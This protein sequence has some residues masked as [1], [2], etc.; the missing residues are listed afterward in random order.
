M[1]ID[2]DYDLIL[3]DNSY[4][5]NNIEFLYSITINPETIT[6]SNNAV[7]SG[8]VYNP[9]FII[10]PTFVFSGENIMA[11][12][13]YDPNLLIELSNYSAG[14]NNNSIIETLIYGEPDS[15]NSAWYDFRDITIDQFLYAGTG[16]QINSPDF[17]FND[18]LANNNPQEFQWLFPQDSLLDISK[19]TVLSQNGI[20][21]VTV[22]NLTP[23]FGVTSILGIIKNI[24]GDTNNYKIEYRFSYDNKNF[25][26]WFTDQNL[27]INA[28]RLSPSKDN[29]LWPEFRI[30]YTGFKKLY[31]SSIIL[32]VISELM[33]NP[34]ECVCKEAAF[35]LP[36][37]P[38]N[39]FNPYDPKIVNKFLDF[40]KKMSYT[41][42][43]FFGHECDYIRIIP[44]RD[45]SDFVLLED[46]LYKE[47]T[48]VP[49]IGF[50]IMVNNNEFPDPI[51]NFTPFGVEFQKPFE[52]HIDINYFQQKFG[53]GTAPQKGDI[54]RLPIENRVYEIKSSTPQKDFMR[55]TLYWRVELGKWQPRSNVVLSDETNK[56]LKDYTTSVSELFGKIQTDEIK[57]K[58][59]PGQLTPTDRYHDEN[60]QIVNYDSW[61]E[62]IDYTIDSTSIFNYYYDNA[63]PFLIGNNTPTRLIEYVDNFDFNL[64]STVSYN[65]WFK[66]VQDNKFKS[67]MPNSNSIV[68]NP[69]STYTI[70]FVQPIDNLNLYTT[71]GWVVL[72]D[73]TIPNFELYAK[74]IRLDKF[75]MVVTAMPEVVAIASAAKSNWTATGIYS[76]TPTYTR[77]FFSN[78]KAGKGILFDSF[79]LNLYRVQ[80]N[81]SYFL[82]NLPNAIKYDEW[83]AV[84][85]NVS[86]EFKEISLSF[87]GSNTNRKTTKLLK[88][89]KKQI[90]LL[91]KPEWLLTDTDNMSMFA[92]NMH[93]TNIRFMKYIINDDQ[94]A[95]FNTQ[96]IINDASGAIII[97][98]AMPVSASGYRGQTRVKT[99][100]NGQR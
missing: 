31:V 70:S 51:F 50:K 78:W 42:T 93:L 67:K 54:I 74:I 16:V 75:S 20:T 58:A 85:L 57:D 15:I 36:Q 47:D 69:D 53:E 62:K 19:M 7:V 48:K 72:N 80:L 24:Y 4:N 13:F 92:G 82:F 66:P 30:Q 59:N 18:E 38:V 100:W 97:D 60:R 81:N 71:G 23:Y 43:E 28:I 3:S 52:V 87:W 6:F 83:S 26:D 45:Y 84:T 40:Q 89:A 35:Q 41:V 29:Q 96:N 2:I 86:N 63:K 33:D 34:P 73:S 9:T 55:N 14:F 94:A 61:I 88:K 95:I 76:V 10:N 99:N 79:G 17:I 27:F 90:S 39:Y 77:I 37:I 11:G 46:G 91:N 98:N 44:D 68:I 65:A 56:I 32:D 8:F 49:C 5:S 22:K 25:S 64:K 12:F 21:T 1:V